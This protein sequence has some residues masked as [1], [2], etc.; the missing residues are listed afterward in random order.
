MYSEGTENCTDHLL[1]QP[2]TRL[3][4]KCK[5]VND[6]PLQTIIASSSMVSLEEQGFLKFFGIRTSLI[7]CT[8][9][10][11]AKTSAL[12][13]VALPPDVVSIITFSSS[14]AKVNFSDSKVD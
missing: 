12:T 7:T 1:I 9:P 5:T 3:H 4:Q 6:Q 2:S 13:T 10:F 14:I 8:T 11:V